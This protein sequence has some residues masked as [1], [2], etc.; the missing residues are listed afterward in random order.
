VGR[1]HNRFATER[2]HVQIAAAAV[3]AALALPA[4]VAGVQPSLSF[5]RERSLLRQRAPERARALR[6]ADARV[7]SAS[8]DIIRALHENP[9][10]RV[11]Y[12]WD[13]VPAIARDARSGP[14]RREQ[15]D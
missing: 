15:Q 10:H 1:S 14:A 3:V 8:R 4:Y 13:P 12:K 11:D 2:V 7:H 5:D 6:T 9:L